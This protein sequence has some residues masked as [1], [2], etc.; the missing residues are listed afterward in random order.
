MFWEPS[1]N[2][3]GAFLWKA[4]GGLL[5]GCLEPSASLLVAF[6]EPSRNLLKPFGE[7]LGFFWELLGTL[8]ASANLLVPYGILGKQPFEVKS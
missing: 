4:S 2:S 5:G 7:L 6:L 8:G 3:F 1:G